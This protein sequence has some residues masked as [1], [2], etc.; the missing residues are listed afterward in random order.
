MF[1]KTNAN[2]KNKRTNDCVIRAIALAENKTWLEVFDELA[3]LE[4]FTNP[5]LLLRKPRVAN[6][7]ASTLVEIQSSSR[8]A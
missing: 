6:C 4:G 1:T 2:P 5:F 7:N 8:P 3:E